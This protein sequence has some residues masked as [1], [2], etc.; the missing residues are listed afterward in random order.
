MINRQQ[1]R[2]QSTNLPIKPQDAV[3]L[4][5]VAE[6]TAQLA[7][8]KKCTKRVVLDK[9]GIY[10]G[11]LILVNEAYAYQ[12]GGNEHSLV[13]VGG[14]DILLE[15][16][17]AVLLDSIMQEIDG[18]QQIAAISG[19]RSGAEQEEIYNESLRKNGEEFTNKYV[20]RPG[21][22]EHQAAL[23]IDLGLRGLDM[24]FICPSF[25]YEGIC[26]RFRERAVSF[27]FIERYPEGKEQLTHISH[28]PWHFRYVGIPH[29]GIMREKGLVLEEYH[30]LLKQYP[31]DGQGLLYQEGTQLMRIS[32]LAAE[33]SELTS[34]CIEKDVPYTV[35]GNN[36]D[37][38]VI[39]EW[40]KSSD[41][42]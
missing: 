3:P 8:N 27:G 10:R 4:K 18:W 32:Y 1:K 7:I 40:R 25:P 16:K 11:S 36:M 29:A 31:H 6:E 21:H 12:E 24:D 34:F 37:G 35:S 33:E 41:I 14:A 42:Y 13:S 38:F 20:A 23:A 26:Q 39:T 28:E 5:A 17:V 22:S 9:A 30:Q 2:K 15:R 19:W